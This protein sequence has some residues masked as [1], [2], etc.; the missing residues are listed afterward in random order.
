MGT[1]KRLTIPTGAAMTQFE[2]IAISTMLSPSRLLLL[3]QQHLGWTLVRQA[4]AET[5]MGYVVFADC[6][7]LRPGVAALIPNRLDGG[8]TLV[9][10]LPTVDYLLELSGDIPPESTSQALSALQ[11]ID[12]VQAAIKVQPSSIKRKAPFWQA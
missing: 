12:E 4:D 11:S 3:L 10:Q 2:L 1:P 5:Q 8:K 7:Q 6:T 9:S